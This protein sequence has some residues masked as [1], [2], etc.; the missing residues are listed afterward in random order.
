[1]KSHIKTIGATNH[2]KEERD[3]NDFY[4]TCGSDVER[5]LDVLKED[6]VELNSLIWEPACGKGHISEVL[7]KKGFNVL[8]SDI[9]K[10]GFFGAKQLDFL[11][12]A[13]RH[14]LSASIGSWWK[15]DIITNPPF[16][17]ALGFIERAM[18]RLEVGGKLLLL[19][20]LRY[21][22]TKQRFHLFQKFPLKFIYVYSYRIDIGKGGV[23]NGGNA[24]AYCWFVWEKGFD[25][26]AV[27]RFI[28]RKDWLKND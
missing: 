9:V 11:E 26:E 8:S 25:G 4:A 10:R 16:K 7:T 5:F 15:G 6:G 23:F 2:T 27:V 20:P 14:V 21:L 3:P 13:P 18:E 22:E 28:S 24:V 19:L 17:F 12:A 1:M